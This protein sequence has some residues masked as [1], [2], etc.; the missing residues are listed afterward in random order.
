MWIDELILSDNLTFIPNPQTSEVIWSLCGVVCHIVE[1]KFRIAFYKNRL[2]HREDGAAVVEICPPNRKNY[3]EGKH[4]C[5][6]FSLCWD[7]Q[8]DINFKYKF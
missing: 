6:D 8:L 7:D 4:Y 1:E 2:L 5:Y 3:R